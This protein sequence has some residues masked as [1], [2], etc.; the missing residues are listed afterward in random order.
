[1]SLVQSLRFAAAVHQHKRILTRSRQ[2]LADI[3]LERFRRL[4][5][6]AVEKS[7][8]YRER[9]RGVDPSRVRPTDLPH[10]TKDEVR[11]NFASIVTDPRLQLAELQAFIRDE[12]NLGG[13]FL[14][15][16][17]VSQTSGSQGPPLTI[18]QDRRCIELIVS[19]MAVRSAPR[20]PTV[21]EGLRRLLVPRKLA[22]ISF[23]RGFYPS[24]TVMEY[25]GQVA[26]R[27]VQVTRLSANQPDLF[28]RLADLQPEVISANASVL[29]SMALN[30]Q[31]PTF[32]RLSHMTS[33]SEELSPVA[34]ERIEAS[35]G[36]PLFDHYGTGECLQLSDGCPHCHGLHVNSD[37]ALLE[38]VDEN[39]RAVPPGELGTKVLVTN[40]ANYAQPFIR[41]EVAD[42]V[43]VN[44]NHDCPANPLPR[45]E[46]IEGRTADLLCIQTNGSRK[47]LSGILFHTVFSAMRGV[48]EWRVR[49]SAGDLLEISLQPFDHSQHE[50][51]AIEAQLR[52]RLAEFGVPASVRIRVE[53]VPELGPDPR[54]GKVRRIVNDVGIPATIAIPRSTAATAWLR[55]G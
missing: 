36:A 29:E 2:R 54:T 18:V 5:R 9:F 31:L 50:W 32:T 46:R 22:A 11:E 48:R 40:L 24:G 39:Y 49:Q 37:W 6:Y 3:Q 47:F 34:R 13:W 35:F 52:N 44:P 7:P 30:G 42:C 21:L 15:Q 20:Q 14:G 26:G 17:A 12:R 45:I 19:L 1:M 41:Y 28:D 43:A 23:R 16:Y 55:A 10:V 38:V 27:F 25:L 4:V 33:S 51:T 8:F 53:F